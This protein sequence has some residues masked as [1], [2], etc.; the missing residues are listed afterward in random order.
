LSQ[1]SLLFKDRIL[2]IHPLDRYN[3]FIIG[4][5]HNCHIHIDSLAVNDKHAQITY[6]N[7]VY[8]IEPLD[9]TANVLINNKKID[10]AVALSDGDRITLGKH[11]LIFSFDERNERDEQREPEFV[12]HNNGIGWIQYLNGRNMGKTVQIKKNMANISD[13]HEHNIAMIAN[14]SD[15]F[16]ISYLKG[17]HSPKVN[18]KRIGERSTRLENNSRISLG[19]QDILFYTH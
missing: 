10:S 19:S 3:H 2:S 17:K 8:L 13:E 5:A 9:D 16:Y 4:H 14:R 12:A 7:Q 6:D 18:N 11:T 1:M 15:G